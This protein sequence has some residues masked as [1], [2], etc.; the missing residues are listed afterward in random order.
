LL[1]HAGPA[2]L[3]DRV[4]RRVQQVTLGHRDFP[5]CTDEQEEVQKASLPAA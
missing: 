1:D 3:V 5:R 4:R 2:R